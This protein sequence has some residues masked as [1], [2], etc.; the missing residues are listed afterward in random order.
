MRQADLM[1]K[2]HILLPNLYYIWQ[3]FQTE[4]T[5]WPHSLFVTF[6]SHAKIFTSH[7]GGDIWK[8]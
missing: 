6:E 4:K 8:V 2:P 5:L 3:I 7:S 1:I